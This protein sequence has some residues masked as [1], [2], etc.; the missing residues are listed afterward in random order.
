[1]SATAAIIAQESTLTKVQNILISQ[2]SPAIRTAYDELEKRYGVRIDFIPFVT[3]EGL[4]E[5]EYRKNRVYPNDYTAIVFM[6][7]NAVDHF[8][9]LC[10]EMRIKMSADTKY[11]C[12][13]EAVAN[14]LQ[15]FILFRKRK[16][17]FGIKT[18]QDL[19]ISLL[20]HKDKEKFLVPCSNLG[21][22]DIGVWLK[23]KEFNYQEVMMY[24]TVSSDLSDLSDITYDILVFFSATDIK[25]L[26]DNFP[27]FKQNE[28]RIAVFGGA[29]AKAVK[30]MGLTI[31]IQ[32]P[33]PDVPSMPMAIEKY[34]LLANK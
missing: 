21:S 6:S 2:A 17:F 4:T 19:A 12:L 28:T 7:K 33:E 9:R 26:F 10:E 23:E 27:D 13:T 29:A 18:V 20:K 14:Y 15:K 3:I 8:F 25:S 11:F 24:Q 32:A 31:H 30:E 22:Q 34:L 1:M 16:V 5:K